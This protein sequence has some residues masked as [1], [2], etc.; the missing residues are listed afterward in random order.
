MSVTQTTSGPSI[1]T[2]QPQ[3]CGSLKSHP[4]MRELVLRENPTSES[5][6]Q[7]L[8]HRTVLCNVALRNRLLRCENWS[9]VR[10]LLQRHPNNLRSIDRY[11]TASAMWLSEIDSSDAKSA[12][13]RATLRIRSCALALRFSRCTAFP[14]SS[15]QPGVNG[16]AL[17]I[18]FGIR[19]E[20]ALGSQPKE[21]HLAC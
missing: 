19:S 16:Q 15:L 10:T 14:R 4:P 8:V 6:K 7:P 20:F 2:G 5:S 13:V 21:T 9:Y 3:R 17:P 12:I 18:S 11:W 1:G